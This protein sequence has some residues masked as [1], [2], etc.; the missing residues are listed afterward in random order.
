MQIYVLIVICFPKFFLLQLLY[1]LMLIIA[2]QILWSNNKDVIIQNL[3]CKTGI[4]YKKSKYIFIINEIKLFSLT[5]CN[6]LC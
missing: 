6:I 3:F 5:M 1:Y 2:Y 4:N